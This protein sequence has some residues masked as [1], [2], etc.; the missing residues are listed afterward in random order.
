MKRANS[1]P[2]IAQSMVVIAAVVGLLCAV[3]LITRDG[4]N[5][6]L[7]SAQIEVELGP[8]RELPAP[9]QLAEDH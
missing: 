5:F 2:A 3:S 9:K 1:L 7:R 4:Y 8:G 6:R